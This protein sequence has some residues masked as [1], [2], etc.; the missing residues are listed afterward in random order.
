M[1]LLTFT[2][3]YAFAQTSLG[4]PGVSDKNKLP[5]GVIVEFLGVAVVITLIIYAAY[6]YMRNKGT[7]NRPHA[8]S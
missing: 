7:G 3:T 6:R 8:T 4:D 2:D 1:L 5:T